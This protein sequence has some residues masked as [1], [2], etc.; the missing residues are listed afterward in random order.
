MWAALASRSQWTR[1]TAVAGLAAL[2]MLAA[3]AQ[4]RAVAP[5]RVSDKG[6]VGLT[7][8]RRL[9]LLPLLPLGVGS[10]EYSSYD[11]S[12]GADD[13]RRGTYS[14]LRQ[15]SVEGC[16]LAERRG[17]GE[18]DSIWFT[19]DAGDVSA[20]GALRIE[21][22]G[23]TIVDASLQ[24]VAD[25]ALGPPFSFPL[26]A[27]RLQSSGGVYIKVPIPFRRSMKVSTQEN[28]LYYHVNYRSFSD[29]A[30]VSSFNPADRAGDV[31]AKLRAAGQRDPKPRAPAAVTVRR[32]FRLAAG[33]RL[34]LPA[35]TGP[36]VITG[37]RVRFARLTAARP[38]EPDPRTALLQS[39]RLAL[40]FD[41]RQTVD[42][43]IGEFFGSGLGPATVRSLLLAQSPLATGYMSSW[44]PMPF[45]RSAS[46][47]L[48]NA[49]STGVLAGEVLIT[50]AP[51]PAIVSALAS[52]RAGYFHATSRSGATTPGQDWSVLAV[53]GRGRLVGVSQTLRGAIDRKYLEGDERVYLNGA[54]APQLH[55][56]GTEDFYEG[57]YF[58]NQGPFTAPFNGSPAHLVDG[59]QCPASDC[60]SVY[61]LLLTDSIAFATGL[62]FGLEHG[63]FN[64]NP[65]TYGSTAYWYG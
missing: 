22:D 4:A 30:G 54:S 63:D 28:P 52:H 15:T 24:K 25:G 13:G 8:L 47:S 23:R 57:G 1:R 45:R 60:N 51:Q 12:G 18:I 56:T 6:P 62:R 17:A 48:R 65:G 40:S 42:S 34:S 53:R 44:W 58:F 11:R 19:R 32:A 16:V 10:G 39:A 35:I 36:G 61:R 46:V 29:G 43:P 41:G 37:L 64:A 5:A 55:G 31:L 3:A 27:N 26:V 14:C 20:T 7:T 50:R 9:D 21:V 33:G 2:V 49:S 38:G 59:P